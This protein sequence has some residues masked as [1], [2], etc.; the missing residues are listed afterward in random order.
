MAKIAHGPAE[1]LLSIVPRGERRNST[2][3]HTVL[4]VA[5][6]ARA[7]DVGLWRVRNVSDHGM[8]LD[9]GVRVT[10]G[11]KLAI[12]LSDKVAIE[13]EA[14][15]W[16][17]RRCGVAFNAPIDCAAILTALHAEQR[18]PDFRPLR[19]EVATRAIAY[20]EKGLHSVAVLNLSPHGAGFAHDGCFQA[21]MKTM[22]LFE[23]G[24]EH[25]GVIQWSRGG[26]AGM[27]LTEP[28]PRASLESASAF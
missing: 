17:G 8:M 14:A 19:L 11:E 4:R 10:P 15:W 13:G 5:R 23:N 20:C 9:A 22:L 18:A 16:D 3:I 6:V 28:F 7:H 26:R 21:G 12:N 24:E 2:R 1:S 25:R 27:Y